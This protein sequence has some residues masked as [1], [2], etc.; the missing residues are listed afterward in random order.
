[1]R[2]NYTL[3]LAIDSTP[4]YSA[5]EMADALRACIDGTSI[6]GTFELV[7]VGT[8]TAIVVFTRDLLDDSGACNVPPIEMNASRAAGLLCRELTGQATLM[9]LPSAHPVSKVIDRLRMMDVT[10]EGL[11]VQRPRLRLVLDLVYEQEHLRNLQAENTAPLVLQDLVHQRF[12]GAA[13]VELKVQP[14]YSAAW[15]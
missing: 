13:V 1:M 6:G 14:D 2:L 7:K 4:D 5:K 11:L 3:K 12:P 8:M 10:V 15:R 9:R